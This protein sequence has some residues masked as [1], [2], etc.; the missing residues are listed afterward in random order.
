MLNIYNKLVLS[1]VHNF[2]TLMMSHFQTMYTALDAV[3][4]VQTYKTYKNNFKSKQAISKS[5]DLKNK[6]FITFRI[7]MHYIFPEVIT[8][9]IVLDSLYTLYF[10]NFNYSETSMPTLFSHLIF[11]KELWKV[12]DISMAFIFISALITYFN[13]IIDKEVDNKYI[14]YFVTNHKDND[15]IIIQNNQPL[16]CFEAKKI[17]TFRRKIKKILPY[18]KVSIVLMVD[19]FCLYNLY[20][21]WTNTF[22]CFVVL[23]TLNL[24]IVYSMNC[25]YFLLSSLYNFFILLTGNVFMIYYLCITA[26]Y[27]Y[28]K[29]QSKKLQ[30]NSLLKKILLLIQKNKTFYKNKNQ[31]RLWSKYSYVNSQTSL[32]CQEISGHN[33]FWC[34]YLTFFYLLYLVDSSYYAYAL[35]FDNGSNYNFFIKMFFAVFTYQFLS[36]LAFVTWQCSKIVYQNGQLHK[37]SLTLAMKFNLIYQLNIR[38]LLTIDDITANYQNVK[39]LKCFI[40][41]FPT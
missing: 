7:Q 21:H 5:V 25:K 9:Y 16:L 40:C 17:V 13:L 18:N 26:Q 20:T 12:G 36:M 38:E 31:N 6:F 8:L 32:L 33:K 34:K 24:F 23:V 11:P 39:S 37:T 4:N 35:F 14:M 29:Q 1:F 15:L 30:Y 3:K 19:V 2:L 41:C 28:L 10:N 27:I 22:H